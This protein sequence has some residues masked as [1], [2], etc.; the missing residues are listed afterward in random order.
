M[1]DSDHTGAIGKRCGSLDRAASR[2]LDQTAA[3]SGTLS[4]EASQNAATR[5]P[6]NGRHPWF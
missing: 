2:D 1:K 6:E 3:I 5:I 4:L